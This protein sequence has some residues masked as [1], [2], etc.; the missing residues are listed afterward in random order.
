MGFRQTRWQKK[1]HVEVVR[2][3]VEMVLIR[4]V[5]AFNDAIDSGSTQIV[6]MFIDKDLSL[7]TYLAH[8]IRL[9]WMLHLMAICAVRRLYQWP[10]F[11]CARGRPQQTCSACV[12]SGT[13]RIS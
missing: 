6:R 10:D 4:D 8:T 2:C 1:G 5:R 3:L 9:V 12:E 11:D 13:M 7:I